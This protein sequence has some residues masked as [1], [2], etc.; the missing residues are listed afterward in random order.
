MFL[1]SVSFS[2]FPV[3]YLF[4]FF[5]LL[6]IYILL[7]SLPF[8]SLRFLFPLVVYPLFVFLLPTPTH[9]PPSVY[10]L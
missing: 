1:S 9:S 7:L 2:L 5:L 8:S 10:L 3:L 6:A 4:V